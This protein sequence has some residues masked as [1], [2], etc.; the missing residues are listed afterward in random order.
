MKQL[1]ADPRVHACWS[2]GGSLRYRL[3]DSNIIK[4]VQSV[5]ASNDDILK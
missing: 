3:V 4:R 2:S 5:Y 1:Q